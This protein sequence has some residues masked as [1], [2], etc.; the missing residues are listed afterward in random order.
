MRKGADVEAA[1]LSTIHGP[2][3]VYFAAMRAG[4]AASN[5]DAKEFCFWSDVVSCLCSRSDRRLTDLPVISAV[6]SPSRP[7]LP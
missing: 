3:A 7:R 5:N 2:R 4:E 1:R 6:Q